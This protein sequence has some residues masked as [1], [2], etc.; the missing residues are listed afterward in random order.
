MFCGVRWAAV[1]AVGWTEA[2][3]TMGS[4]QQEL[5]RGLAVVLEAKEGCEM[6]RRR[7]R[8]WEVFLDC[9]SA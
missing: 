9:Q 3:P 6:L 4:G 1:V 8:S 7:L 2:S 5:L